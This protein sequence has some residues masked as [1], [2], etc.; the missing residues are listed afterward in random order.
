MIRTFDDLLP[1]ALDDAGLAE[2]SPLTRVDDL[3]MLLERWVERGW[4]RALD[5]AFVAFLG[6]LDPQADPLVLVAAAFT[7]HQLGHGHVCLDLYETLKEPDFALSLPPEGDQQDGAML[8]PSQLLAAL[9]GAAWCQALARSVLVAEVGDSSA[10]ALQNHWC[11]RSG[12]CTCA[13]TGPTSAVSRRP[14]VS[15]S[16][17]LTRRQQI[18]RSA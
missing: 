12:V 9:D 7:S 11:W 10:E 15:D 18:C 2:L 8:L 17:N 5:R 14:C 3:L 4:L 13:A 6:E 16:P 1:T